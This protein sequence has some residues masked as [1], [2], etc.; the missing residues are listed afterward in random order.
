MKRALVLFLSLTIVSSASAQIPQ[1]EYAARRAA[2]AKLIGNGV[3]L[4]FGSPEPE[5]DYIAFNQN[6]PFNYLS[7]FSEPNAALVF[8]V[9]NGEIVGKAKLFVE[10]NDPARE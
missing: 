4:A 7:G 8:Q 1:S 10:A 2:L 6:S 9:K 5:Q 3:V